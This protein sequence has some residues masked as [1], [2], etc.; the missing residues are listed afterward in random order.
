ML[1]PRG[2]LAT[3]VVVA[4]LDLHGVGA[5]LALVLRGEQLRLHVRF[6]MGAPPAAA[7]CQ[8][9]AVRRAARPGQE[10]AASHVDHRRT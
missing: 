3:M 6:G 5:A 2:D 4:A 8:P 7:T 9:P 10:P 1:R